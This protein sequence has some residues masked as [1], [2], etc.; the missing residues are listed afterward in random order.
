M[1]K[2][3]NKRV[4]FMSSR[5]Y[6]SKTSKRESNCLLELKDLHFKTIEKRQF[7]K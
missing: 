3:I 1:L 2:D 4:R 7:K 6:N 5:I